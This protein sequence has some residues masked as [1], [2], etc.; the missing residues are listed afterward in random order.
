[1]QYDDMASCLVTITP[2][3]YTGRYQEEET[4]RKAAES[5]E[6][7]ATTNL[8]LKHSDVTIAK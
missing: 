4:P 7:D 3:C 1:M 2:E 8:L 6:G 5:E